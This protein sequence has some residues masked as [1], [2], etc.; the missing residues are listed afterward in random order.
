[1]IRFASYESPARRF[2]PFSRKEKKKIEKKMGG[3]I[4]DEKL[5]LVC[6]T[7]ITRGAQGQPEGS[8]RNGKLA[9][10]SVLASIAFSDPLATSQKS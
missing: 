5:P 10:M 1:M 3:K 9:R 2:P 7:L 4:D 8:R 6:A